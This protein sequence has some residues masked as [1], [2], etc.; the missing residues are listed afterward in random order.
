MKKI[1]K[2]AEFYFFS[3]GQLADVL[4]LVLEL[5]M[6]W[7]RH[8]VYRSIFLIL[9]SSSSRIHVIYSLLNHLM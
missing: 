8:I 3:R 2:V 1:S 7:S 4:L 5:D 6:S 9:A